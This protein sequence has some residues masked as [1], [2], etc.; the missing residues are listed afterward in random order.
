MSADGKVPSVPKHASTGLYVKS[1]N[2]LKLRDQK[3][4][5]LLQKLR[6]VAPWIEDSDSPLARRWCE[7]EILASQIYGELR[8]GGYTNAEGE[9]RRLLTD[10][11]QLVLAQFALAREL[12]LSPAARKALRA[13]GTKDVFDLPSAMSASEDATTVPPEEPS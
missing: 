4:R 5:R 2:G 3:V 11:R 6:V 8:D 10:Y 13:N 1:R 9:S 7:L 12:G